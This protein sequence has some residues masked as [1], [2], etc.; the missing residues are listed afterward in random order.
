MVRSGKCYDSS[1][2]CGTYD[3]IEMT[4]RLHNWRRGFVDAAESSLSLLLSDN[5]DELNTPKKIAEVIAY[6][7]SKT[8][9]EESQVFQWKEVDL[10]TGHFKARRTQCLISIAN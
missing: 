2:L 4:V 10:D 8:P 5:S 7:L 3:I 9:D 1:L 6:Y